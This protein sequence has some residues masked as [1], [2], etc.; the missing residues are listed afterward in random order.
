MSAIGIG[1]AAIAAFIIS[2][3]FYALVPSG[4]APRPEAAEP[5]PDRP[6]PWQ[7]VIELLR[8]AITATLVAGLLIATD[9]NGPTARALLGLVLWA[10]PLVL[11]TGSVVWER[12]P[13]RNAA[14]HAGD[15][16]IKLLAI[17]AIVGAF[18]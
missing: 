5:T 16:L 1:V 11:L 18:A 12:V 4:P 3:V 2:F 10:L 17:G 7:I 14:L 9:E 6:A 13:V 15:W 8:S